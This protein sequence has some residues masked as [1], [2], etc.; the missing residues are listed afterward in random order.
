[1]VG[2]FTTTLISI[3]RLI[4]SVDILGARGP[5]STINVRTLSAASQEDTL[6]DPVKAV[7]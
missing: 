1:M 6:E 3:L 5:T 2:I 7:D 4:V